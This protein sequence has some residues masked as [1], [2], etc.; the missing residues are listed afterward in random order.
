MII[1]DPNKLHVTAVKIKSVTSAMGGVL[2]LQQ[3]DGSII[4]KSIPSSLARRYIKFYDIST[5]WTPKNGY[6][7]TYEDH[8]I[9]I[10][11]TTPGMPSNIIINLSRVCALINSMPSNI[12]YFDGSC[13]YTYNN[14]IISLGFNNFFAQP[15]IAIPTHELGFNIGI[16]QE[17]RY[18]VGYQINGRSIMS[19]PIWRRFDIHSTT[20]DIGLPNNFDTYNQ[21]NFVNI[22]FAIYAGKH[23]IK[24]FDY[25]VI[26]PLMLPELIIDMKT[27]NLDALPAEVKYITNIHMDF[28][29]CVAW[30]LGLMTRVTNLSELMVIRSVLRYLISHCCVNK[31]TFDHIA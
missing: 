30:C 1:F 3:P 10:E 20:Q 14:D 13:I 29:Q 17:T 22:N 16:S 31:N 6:I 4:K 27:I 25:T 21:E 9:A 18:C 5:Y 24:I 8:I 12:W 19:P 15:T 7:I 28:Q 2:T 23:L 11:A 26:D